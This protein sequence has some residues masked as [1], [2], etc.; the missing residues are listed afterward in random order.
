MVKIAYKNVLPEAF[1]DNGSTA[2]WGYLPLKIKDYPYGMEKFFSPPG[3]AEYFGADC[4]VLAKTNEEKYDRAQALMGKVLQMAHER[5]MQMAMGFE[6]GV[7]P[8]EYASIRT[9]GDMYWL[10]NGSLVYNPFDPDASGILYATIDNILESYSG[11]DWIYL[12]LNEHCMFG[13]DTEAALQSKPMADYY[14][15]NAQYYKTDLRDEST[16]VLGVWSQAYIQKAY[17]YIKH[18]APETKIVIGGWGSENQMALLL[19]GLH[20]TLPDD[21]VF[22]M[23]NPMQGQKGHPSFFKEIARERKIW[24]I[25][26]LEGD[27]SLWH[28]QPRVQSLS[29]Q[30][31][32]SEE[33]ELNGVV[34]IHWRTEEVGQNFET[35]ASTA[36]KPKEAQSTLEN[37]EDFCAR[38]YGQKSVKILAPLLTRIDSTAI[39]SN[40]SS[41][42]YFAY[43]PEW[44]RLTEQQ[45]DVVNHLIES[46]DGCIAI[47]GTVELI[48]NLEWLRAS[49]EFTLLLHEVGLSMEPAWKL[50]EAH[51]SAIGPMALEGDEMAEALKQLEQTPMEQMLQVF[52]SRVRSRGE[53]GELSSLIQ[54][55][56]TEYSRLTD[57][58]ETKLNQL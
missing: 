17:A 30:V 20:K 3:G 13:I 12:W 11:I 52:A 55:V 51:L 31:K 5:D 6:F 32:Q 14:S 9:R 8:P 10:G 27:A 35:F 40:I 22:S 24:S 44:G 15:E 42:V 58:L 53:L 57:F 28:L 37:Y 16:T 50:R 29:R 49:Y 26:W 36:Y 38:E 39:L 1:F 19:K 4:S 33:D 54:R 41:P 43:Q 21:I 45:K 34:A 23:L 47:E 48:E 56:W 2:R 7:A 18:K 46:I 25:P